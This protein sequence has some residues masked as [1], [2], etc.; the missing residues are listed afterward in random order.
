MTSWPG[1]GELFAWLAAE[2]AT[3]PTAGAVAT[4][5]A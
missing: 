2:A 4:A 5:A 3:A 1:H